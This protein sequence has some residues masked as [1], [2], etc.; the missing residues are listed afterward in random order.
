M[1]VAEIISFLEDFAPSE[2]AE[3]WDNVGLLVGKSHYDVKKILVTL[4]LNDEVLKEAIENEVDLIITHHPVIFK[5]LNKINDDLLIKAI[6]NDIS[7]YSLHT[8]LDAADGGVNDVLAEKIGLD[9]IKAFGMI[10]IG[11]INKISLSDFVSKVKTV[12]NTNGV[13]ACGRDDMI[14]EKVAV[15]GGSGGGFVTDLNRDLCDV[16]LTGEASYHRAQYADENGF[17]LVAAGHFETENPVV[18]KLVEILKRKFNVEVL[19]S[20]EKNVYNIR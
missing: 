17:A 5:P 18:E 12:L 14:V 3:E 7:V 9:D 6:R 15:L 10:R 20:K 19:A 13:R 8:N 11:T 4:D 16:F 2:L 1:K